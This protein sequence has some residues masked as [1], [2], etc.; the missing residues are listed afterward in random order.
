MI[1]ININYCY[2]LL[3][4]IYSQ[5]VLEIQ[6]MQKWRFR[7]WRFRRKKVSTRLEYYQLYQNKIIQLYKLSLMGHH[8]KNIFHGNIQVGSIYS[9]HLTSIEMEMSLKKK[10]LQV[11]IRLR[12][13]IGLMKLIKCHRTWL[14]S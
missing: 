5:S 8:S 2:Y 11:L 13:G 6:A 1:D 4:S 12:Y 10:H 14:K 9:I 3:S 7:Q